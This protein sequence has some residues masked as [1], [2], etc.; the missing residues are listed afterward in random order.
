MFIN[1]IPVKIDYHTIMIRL[2]YKKKTADVSEAFLAEVKE[3][4]EETASLLELKAS[5]K[6]LKILSKNEESTTLDLSGIKRINEAVIKIETLKINS[7]SLSKFL[8]DSDE[9][10]IMAITGGKTVMDKVEECQKSEMTKAVVIDAAAGEI[11]DSGLDYLMSLF[12]RNLI[13]ESRNLL[14]R[15]FSPGYGDL[16]LEIQRTIY[17]IL[18]LNKLDIT[19]TD[20]CMMIPQKSVIAITGI[21]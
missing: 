10:L 14:S 8:K 9:V 19:L 11:V 13:R 2:G 21:I 12:S 17:D 7:R 5:V 4:I 15:R 20:S 16:S 3:Y 1:S 6:R 18:E